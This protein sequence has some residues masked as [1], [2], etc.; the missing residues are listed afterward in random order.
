MNQSTQINLIG[1][2]TIVNS[3]SSIIAHFTYYFFIVDLVVMWPLKLNKLKICL[4][5]C[6]S[7]VENLES[8][9]FSVPIVKYQV[10][11]FLP[12]ET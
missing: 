6:S 11:I 8:L 10:E 7:G 1:C 12:E 9:K 2:D 3:P 5:N 4:K